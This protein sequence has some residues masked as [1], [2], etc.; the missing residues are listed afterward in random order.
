[1]GQPV[2][3]PDR[4]K[5]NNYVFATMMASC[6]FSLKSFSLLFA[7]IGFSDLNIDNLLSFYVSQ[8]TFF[9]ISELP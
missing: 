7:A 4:L 1:M 9:S 5:E 3:S 8:N 2:D 6:F